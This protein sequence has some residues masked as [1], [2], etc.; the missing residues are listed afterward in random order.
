MRLKVIEVER[1]RRRLVMSASLAEREY[2]ASRREELFKTLNVGDVLSGEVRSLRPFGAF[3]D[4]GGA[5]GLL[6]VSEIG[7]SNISHPR[8][9]LEVG[10]KVDVQVIRIDPEGQRIALSR[11]RLLANPWDTVD[12]RYKPGD[13]LDAAITRI[14]DFGAFAE[15]E[16]GIEGLIHISEVADIAVAEPLK[17]ISVGD[18]VQVKVLRVDR[19][20]QRVGLSLRQAYGDAGREDVAPA[21][22]APADDAPAEA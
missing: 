10:Q 1:R 2:Q 4:I 17:T 7:W 15:L 21:D 20:R 13:V 6:H 11:K 16:P 19:K 14:V 5:D 22:V 9:A 3:V 12:E 18:K 8:E